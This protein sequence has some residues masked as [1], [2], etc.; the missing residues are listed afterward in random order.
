MPPRLRQ[1]PRQRESGSE[2]RD[3]GRDRGSGRPQRVAQQGAHHGHGGVDPDRSTDLGAQPDRRRPALD[4][5]LPAHRGQHRLEQRRR[6]GRGAARSG[7]SRSRRP[8]ASR[9]RRGPGRR[10]REVLVRDRLA[11]AAGHQEA[12]HR[13]GGA[14][15]L[16]ER[17][18]PGRVV[19][20]ARGREGPAAGGR[21]G[22]DRAELRVPDPEEAGDQDRSRC[23]PA[24]RSGTASYTGSAGQSPVTRHSAYTS[25]GSAQSRCT[26]REAVGAASSQPAAATSAGL[27]A[28]TNE[29][30]SG[31]CSA[32][33]LV[34]GQRPQRRGLERRRG[35]GE[36][37]EERDRGTLDG[38]QP[39]GPAGRRELDGPVGR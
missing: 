2:H 38:G 36:L 39:R 32:P 13:L 7:R 20:G 5:P 12:A 14:D 37:V 18:E 3:L 31:S 9:G 10:P 4:G 24:S 21:V 26:N 25:T 29:T 28:A 34:V 8:A 15:R 1:Q 23:S 33:D 27:A 16:R 22:G 6:H 19:P 30:V 35:R 11:Q 17:R